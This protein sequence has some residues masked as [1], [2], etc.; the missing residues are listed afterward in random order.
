MAATA[1]APASP[2]AAQLIE[3]LGAALQAMTL[4]QRFDP[5]LSGA[6]ASGAADAHLPIVLHLQAEHADDVARVLIDHDIP[7]RMRE[8]R[9]RVP[10]AAA[11]LLPGV[12]FFAG[13]QE[14]LIWIFTEAQF[15]QRLPVGDE[16]A[17]S[18]RLTATATRRLLE[19]AQGGQQADAP[20]A[21]AGSLARGA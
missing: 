5:R 14:F 12:S 2:A 16:T 7:A 17:P 9:L 18:P 1:R 3:Q 8:T 15:R 4:L 13:A 6:L 21:S 11:Q 20:T 19:A 10:R